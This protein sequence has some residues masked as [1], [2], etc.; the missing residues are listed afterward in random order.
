MGKDVNVCETRAIS[1]RIDPSFSCIDVNVV[2]A[3]RALSI[4]FQLRFCRGF[5]LGN[6]HKLI[7]S[8][9]LFL[10]I[11]RNLTLSLSLSLSLWVAVAGRLA[12][13]VDFSC[14]RFPIKPLKEKEKNRSNQTPKN[15][16]TEIQIFH[17]LGS[18]HHRR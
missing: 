18:P 12:Y 9:L 13:G 10:G 8:E 1:T 17:T 4:F 14:S 15:T 11:G 3:V 2:G 7:E 16:V 5:L 6:G